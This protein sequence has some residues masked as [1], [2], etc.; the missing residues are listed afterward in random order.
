MNGW[1]ITQIVLMA[2]GCGLALAKHGDPK[3][4]NWSFPVSFFAALIK[5]AILYM[6]GMWH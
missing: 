6:A 1:E 2:A 4:G 3:E 5:A